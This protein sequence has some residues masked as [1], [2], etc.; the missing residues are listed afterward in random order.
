VTVTVRVVREGC[1]IGLFPWEQ[2]ELPGA[3]EKAT[4]G[5]SWLGRGTTALVMQM[6]GYKTLF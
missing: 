5:S 6:V 2:A 4:G 1:F 3:R